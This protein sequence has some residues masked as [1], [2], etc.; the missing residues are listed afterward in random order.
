MCNPVP[1]EEN[2]IQKLAL[3][4]LSITPHNAGCERVFSILEWFTNKR[5][6]KVI[7]D[8][9]FSDSDDDDNENNDNSNSLDTRSIEIE[10]WVNIDDSEL[11]RLLN[12]NV[13]VVIEPHPITIN[14]GSNT[15]DIETT[16]DSV[17]GTT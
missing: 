13:S 15:F 16:L 6:T 9:D 10:R 7:S 5:R 12:V 14:H 1:E 3:K 8:D 17:L 4:I 2:H 11:N